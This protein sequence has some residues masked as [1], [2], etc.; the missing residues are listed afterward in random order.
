MTTAPADT[1]LSSD[2]WSESGTS[3]SASPSA[4]L[5]AVPKLERSV[6]AGSSVTSNSV[7]SNGDTSRDSCIG[8]RRG[9]NRPQGTAF[10]D[11]AR[12]RDSVMSLGTIAHLQHYFARTG[13]LDGK[14]AQLAREDPFKKEPGSRTA[15]G[16]QHTPTSDP[17]WSE[18]SF[19]SGLAKLDI[20]NGTASEDVSILSSPDQMSFDGSFEEPNTV[21]LPPTVSTYK[22]KSTYVPPPP[23]MNVLRRELREALED[24]KKLLQ[25]VQADQTNR[26]A[27]DTQ[28]ETNV[29]PAKNENVQGWHEI[30]GLQVLD[31]TTLAIRAAKNFYTAHER[32]HRLYSIRSERRIRS[33]LFVVLEVLKKM[34]TRN[35]AHGMKQQEIDQI[36]TWATS[37]DTLVSQDE[38][39]EKAE[40]EAL[41]KSEWQ[42]GDWTGREREREWLFLKSFDSDP[43]TL[44]EWTLPSDNLADLPS[45]FLSTMRDG[46]RLVRLHNELV[47]KS[48]RQFEEIKKYH[49]D[50]E[51]PYRCAEN[52][53]YWIKAAELRWDCFLKVDVAGVVHSAGVAAWHTFDDALLTWCK[54]VREQISTEWTEH[55]EALMAERPIVRMDPGHEQNALSAVPW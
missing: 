31:L 9:F 26:G 14:G 48:R 43:D 51:K 18:S 42:H 2:S 12:N 44:L 17:N 28:I 34:A 35:F 4:A 47:R 23:N 38:E 40:H 49:Q 8:R 37:I 54:T 50:V 7:L 46:R 25:D 24:A 10:A 19:L 22:Q 16:S 36:S 5:A 39:A 15:S 6:S 45:P 30:Q 33:D 1:S 21:I 53:R 3:P 11:S 55:R 13:L 20:P 32:P 27:S 41:Q 52:L 29:S